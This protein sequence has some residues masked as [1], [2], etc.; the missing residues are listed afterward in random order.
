[1]FT[2]LAG[3]ASTS[4]PPPAPPAPLSPPPATTAKTSAGL[5]LEAASAIVAAPDRT[6][7]DRKKDPNRHPAEFLVFLGIAPGMHVAD[8]SATTGYTTELLARAVGPTGTVYGQNDPMILKRFAEKPWAERLARPA[9]KNVVRSDR[10]FDA[11][12][13]PEA[14]NLDLVTLVLFYHDT[15]WLK[16]NRDAM[17]RAI[18]AALKPGGAYVVVDS[19]AKAGRGIEDAETLHRIEQTT[20]ETEVKSAG[21]TLVGQSD[22]L[23]HP[24]DTR[25]W[26]S[27]PGG[28]DAR[29]GTEDC[30]V[31][32]FQKPL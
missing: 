2:L 17:N 24:E 31:V 32:K 26:S 6:P 16:A 9:D 29:V 1:M 5:S 28:H 13:P 18:F 25:D 12:L 4:A 14:K 30:F 10:A 20:L 27:S 11:P 23:R 19:S 21:F 3:C 8:I 15:V 7:E 22:I